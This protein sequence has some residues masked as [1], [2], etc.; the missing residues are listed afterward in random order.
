MAHRPKWIQESHPPAM[1]RRHCRRSFKSACSRRANT[2]RSLRRSPGAV[3]AGQSAGNPVLH[4]QPPVGRRMEC[5]YYIISQIRVNL[6]LVLTIKG[7]PGNARKILALYCTFTAL[8][9]K[10]LIINGAGEGNRTLVSGL[11]RPHS[12]IEPH[13]LI[14]PSEYHPLQPLGKFVLGLVF[15]LC[16]FWP[17][18]RKPRTQLIASHGAGVGSFATTGLPP[19]RRRGKEVGRAVAVRNL[20]GSAL[21]FRLACLNSATLMKH[22]RCLWIIRPARSS[23]PPPWRSPPASWTASPRQ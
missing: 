18:F 14:S 21:T 19:S 6:F 12:T 4:W 5:Q 11:G 7:N 8:I 9:R 17:D 1:Q 15:G 22:F 10:S 16:R 23:P 3:R 2:S 13:P 20:L